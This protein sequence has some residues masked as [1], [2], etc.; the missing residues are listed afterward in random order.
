MTYLPLNLL[1]TIISLLNRQLTLHAKMF[2]KSVWKLAAKVQISARLAST[3]SSLNEVV[4]A[5]AVRTPMGS[6]QS[7][8]SSL[9]A[10]QLGSIAIKSAVDEAGLKSED[11]QEVYMGNVLQAGQG[12]APARQAALG[13]C[14]I[15][16]INILLNG[17]LIFWTLKLENCLQ[18][19]CN[20]QKSL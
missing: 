20:K 9:P 13:I 16:H 10:T 14:Q 12:Q 15:Y 19:S 18:K 6:F 3:A 7:S 11:V 2:F 5:S 8:F 4:V 1:G 17:F